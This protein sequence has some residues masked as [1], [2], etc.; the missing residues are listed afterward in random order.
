MAP[1]FPVAPPAGQTSGDIYTVAG[2]GTGGYASTDGGPATSA[3]LDYPADVAVDNSGNLFIADEYNMRIREVSCVT[4]AS[5]GGACTPSAGQTA[6]D[7]YTAVGLG[8]AGYGPG[9][10]GA[11]T[12][13]NLYYPLGVAV[14]SAGDIIIGDNDN[15]RIRFVPC[16]T[17]TLTCTPPAGDTAKDIYTIA[18]TGSNSYYGVGIPPLDAELYYPTDAVSDP[19]GDIYIADRSNCV[20]R[21]VNSGTGNITTFAGIQGSCGSA[22]DGGPATSAHLNNPSGLAF[23]SSG[24]L[25]IADNGNCVVRE[26]SGGTM[27]TVAGKYA[28]GYTGDGGA[29]TSAEL[30]YPFGVAVDASGHLYIADEYNHAVREVSGGTI[31]TFAGNKTLGYGYSGDGGPASGSQ[32]Y[33]P[34]Q[35]AVDAF[36][37]VYIADQYN[38]RIRKVNATTGIISTVAGNGTAGFQGDG[39]LATQTSLYY[40]IGVGVD[41]AG[42]VLIGDTDNQRVRLV[43]S[44]GIIHTI[45]GT[46]PTSSGYNGNDIPA[47]LPSSTSLMAQKLILPGTSTKPTIITGSSAGSTRCWSSVRCPRP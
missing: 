5:G 9:D 16:D 12:S 20:V 7:I 14:D 6:L 41:L 40:P 2:D 38:H 17:N 37:N 23:D 26:V 10:G 44:S 43:D 32:L 13:A 35:V 29:A 21:E 22:G 31:T 27:S 25:Y 30:Y 39:G 8:T 28:C 1:A 3:E 42:D 24:N 11:A 33:Y 4:T 34:T 46:T 18:G 45:A 47:P 15:Y 36:G 19:S